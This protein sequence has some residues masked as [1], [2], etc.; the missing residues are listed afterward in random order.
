M[1]LRRSR[2]WMC[3]SLSCVSVEHTYGT[4]RIPADFTLCNTETRSR[5]RANMM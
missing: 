5:A 4:T 1:F 3:G 2:V